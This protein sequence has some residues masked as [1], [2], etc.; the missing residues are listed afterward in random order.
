MK[1]HQVYRNLHNGKWSVQSRIGSTAKLYCHADEAVMLDCVFVV[2]PSGVLRVREHKRKFVHAFVRGVYA[3]QS[4]Q[5]M[6]MSILTGKSQVTD[7]VKVVYNPY[8]FLTFVRADNMKPVSSSSVVV[9][10][11]DGTVMA[12]K[13]S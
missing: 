7:W 10:Q 4:N 8:K 6:E 13:P 3:G 9:M 11:K 5:S 12:F 2:Q 1:T